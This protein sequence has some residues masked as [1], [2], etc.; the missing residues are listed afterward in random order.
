M[1]FSPAKK[2]VAGKPTV[3]PAGK[4]SS[5]REPETIDIK[6]TRESAVLTYYGEKITTPEELLR[7]AKI[8]TAIWEI[9]ETTINNWE[10]GGKRNLG[11]H[12][13]TGRWQGERL[14]QMGLRQVTI[15]LRRKLRKTWQDALQELMKSGFAGPKL[16]PVKYGKSA[17]GKDAKFMLEIALHDAHFGKLC[18][19]MET[20]EN[21][22]LKIAEEVY[23]RAIDD[24]LAKVAHL[25]I[26]LVTFPI[27]SDFFHVDNWIGTTSNGTPV[28]STDDRFSKIFNVGIRAISYAIDRCREIAPVNGY[29]LPGNHDKAT[30]W[31]LTRVLMER[32][33]GDKAVT[34]DDSM[35][36]RKYIEYGTSLIGLAHGDVLKLDKLPLIMAGE[37]K[38]AWART[39]HRHVHTGHLHKKGRVS[40]AAGDTYNGVEVWVLPSLSG[41]DLWH[42]DNGYVKNVRA[43]EAYIWHRETGYYGHVSSSLI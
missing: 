6:E 36:H 30:S 39:T 43:G 31:F 24:L 2:S 8:D 10:V 3:K 21:Y 17:T 29:W 38:E 16:S 33:R 26:E 4:K 14:W 23:C 27:G 13:K 22:D 12:N 18:W 35:S 41:C 5:R 28:D 11:Q 25:P 40:H 7:H 15:K 1:A 34:I 42:F 9:A 37:A 20:G 19:A 32:Y